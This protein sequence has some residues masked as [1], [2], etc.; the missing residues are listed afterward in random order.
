MKRSIIIVLDSFGIG[1]AP[2]AA[3]FKDEG[4]ATYQNTY[5]KTHVELTNMVKMG[6][7]NIDGVNLPKCDKP[8][9]NYARLEELSKGKDTTIGHWE[10]AGIVSPKPF[11]TF[12]NGFPREIMDKFEAYVGKKSLCNKPASGTTVIEELGDEHVRTGC[13]IVYTSA[14]S[15]FQIACHT[16]VVPLE[17]LYDY[18]E[19]ARSILTGDYAVGR[20]IARPFNGKSGEYKRTQDRKD[21]SLVP[22]VDTILDVVKN[23]GLNSVAVGKIEDIFAFKGITRSIHSHN[24]VEGLDVTLSLIKEDFDGLIFTNLVDTD[25]VYGHRNDYVGYANCLKYTDDYLPRIFEAMKEGD[26]LIITADHGCDPTTPSTDH[27]REYVPM[28]CYVKGQTEGK[29]LGTIKGFD[30]VSKLVKEHLNLN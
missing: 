8:I 27:S 15:V 26:Q 25:M 24:N 29:N 16:D 30:F 6:L 21:F 18:C 10:I 23:A 20:V 5:E 9:A 12:P 13:P 2:D 3:A 17:K 4:S 11:P 7:N 14:D 22:P 1:E 28:L 19:Y